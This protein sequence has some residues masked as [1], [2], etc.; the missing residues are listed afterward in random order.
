M[1][2]FQQRGGQSVPAENKADKAGEEEEKADLTTLQAALTDLEEKIAKLNEESKK[3]SYKTLVTETQKMVENHEVT[4]EKADKQLE[5]VKTAIKE[6]EEA[7]KK[8]S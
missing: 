6:V 7:I 4:Q 3:D 1:K 8:R 2:R 5:L